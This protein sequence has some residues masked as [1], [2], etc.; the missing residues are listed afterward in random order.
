[1]ATTALFVEIIIVGLEALACVLAM[2]GLVTGVTPSPAALGRWSTLLKDWATLITMVVVAGAYI[3]GVLIDR[4]ADDAYTGLRRCLKAAAILHWEPWPA[5]AGIMRLW[6]MKESDGIAKFIDYQR[7]RLRIARATVLNLCVAWL[8]GVGYVIRLRES[9][10][11]LPA[12]ALG[13]LIVIVAAIY[14]T[15]GINSAFEKRLLEAYVM[16]R[17]APIDNTVAAAVCY[18]RTGPGADILLVRTSGAKYWTFP[19]GHIK[20]KERDRPWKAAER[21]AEEEAGVKGMVRELPIGTYRYPTTAKAGVDVA[22]YLVAAY[23][24]EVTQWG[25]GHER[26]RQPSWFT[27]AEAKAKLAE[28]GREAVYVTQQRRVIDAALAALG[29]AG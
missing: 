4:F 6:V 10:W 27:A 11:V 2:V 13:G 16:L 12:S 21:E 9:D 22:E 14:A 24:L 3:L 18:R 17:T 23:L 29:I 7:S 25:L 26:G 19:K 20:K 28:D 5:P 15:E 1:M 8:I